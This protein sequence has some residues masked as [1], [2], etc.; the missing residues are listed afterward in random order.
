[1]KK[2]SALILVIIGLLLSCAAF[3]PPNERPV[4]QDYVGSYLGKRP[5]SVFSI[6]PERRVVIVHL[7]LDKNAKK[8]SM[9]CAE[10]SPDIAENIASSF[11]AI[12]EASTKWK[13]DKSASAAVEFSKSLGTTAVTLFNRTQ[14]VQLFRDGLFNLCQAYINGLMKNDE[15]YWQKYSELLKSASD[16]IAKE[17]PNVKEMKEVQISKQT[18]NAKSSAESAMQ[19]AE[20]AAIRAENAAKDIENALKEVKK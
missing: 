9:F 19:R 1:M 15:D 14:G 17:I 20:E 11:R 10:P 16:L 2:D 3:T 7:N 6:T 18:L 13:E 5:A 12:A 4:Q 8:F